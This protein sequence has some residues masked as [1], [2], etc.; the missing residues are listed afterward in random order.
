MDMS[1]IQQRLVDTPRNKW[2]RKPIPW[3]SQPVCE[4]ILRTDNNG[5]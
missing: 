2:E 4:V 1:S 3:Y 5:A